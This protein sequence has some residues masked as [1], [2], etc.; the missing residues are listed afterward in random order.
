MLKGYTLSVSDYDLSSEAQKKTSMTLTTAEK[1][2]DEIIE[3]YKKG[4]LERLPGMT[5]EETRESMI[6][7]VLERARQDNYLTAEQDMG[8]NSNPV[9][10]VKIGAKGGSINIVQ[11]ASCL[12]QTT[13]RGKRIVRGYRS[14]TLPYF[15]ED[16]ISAKARGFIRN[17]YKSGLS[18]TEFFFH[19]MSGRDSL[20]DK[21]I[22]TAKSGY[23]Q[24]RLVNALLDISLKEDHSVRDAAGTIVQFKYGEDGLN[25]MKVKDKIKTD[26]YFK[27]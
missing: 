17:S 26:K 4:K 2:V 11:M 15:K 8:M 19:A 18:P 1:K 14:K 25:P 22:N 12:G 3:E 21:G 24:R 20:I 16:D 7:E 10:T 9:L 23:M 13:M 6:M 27:E 5:L